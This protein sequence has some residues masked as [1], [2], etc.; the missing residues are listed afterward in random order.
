MELHMGMDKEVIEGLWIRTKGRAGTGDFI[1]E[2][3]HGPPDQENQADEALC[4]QKGADPGPHGGLQVPSDIC[5]RDNTAEHK[6]CTS[7][8]ECTGDNF[9]L[10]VTE[11]PT[12]RGVM[13]DFILNNKK[14]LV[15]NV[16]LKAAWATVT[17]KW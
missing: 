10:Q 8:L 5:W 16:K 9:L 7:F 17:M 11:E 13:L 6:Q 1:M 15:R 14:G 3:R 4:G 2:V 12:R